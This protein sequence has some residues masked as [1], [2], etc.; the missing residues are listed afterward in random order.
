MLAPH[1]QTWQTKLSE[2]GTSNVY[3]FIS[4]VSVFF[5]CFFLFSIGFF[6][7]FCFIVF[8][9]IVVCVSS[10]VVCVSIVVDALPNNQR[11]YEHTI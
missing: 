8:F 10:I 3:G 4:F 7:L 1:N 5:C 6:L 2:D 11:T 9:V